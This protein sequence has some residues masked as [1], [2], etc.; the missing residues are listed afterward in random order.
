MLH[1][2]T[3]RLWS[4]CSVNNSVPSGWEI[5]FNYT[6]KSSQGRLGVVME[7]HR[8]GTRAAHTLA[9][10]DLF[11][12]LRRHTSLAPLG[13]P[14]SLCTQLYCISNSYMHSPH[15]PEKTTRKA[16]RRRR[17]R[18][19]RN[20]L[21]QQK[22]KHMTPKPLPKKK[23]EANVEPKTPNSTEIEIE[24]KMEMEY[25]SNGAG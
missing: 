17:R 2:L 21:A 5:Y 8:G 24:I 11:R 7:F 23:S 15:L 18:S 22:V 16:Y 3:F 9:P 1:S 25:E 4:V 12:Q 13:P 14:L 6:H 20:C 19:R 10:S